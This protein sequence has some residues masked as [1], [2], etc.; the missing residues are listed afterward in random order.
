VSLA[1][2][3]ATILNAFL[4]STFAPN[5]SVGEVR[6]PIGMNPPIGVIIIYSNWVVGVAVPLSFSFFVGFLIAGAIKK[7]VK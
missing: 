7:F 4:L 1:F 3:I 6:F 2:F 5:F